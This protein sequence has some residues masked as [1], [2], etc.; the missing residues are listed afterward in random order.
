MG[1]CRKSMHASS[2][3]PNSLQDFEIYVLSRLNIPK[4]VM[5]QR[6]GYFSI[7]ESSVKEQDFFFVKNL[8]AAYF[9]AEEH[10]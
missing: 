1:Q 2:P 8:C 5:I 7:R 3:P 10:T 6:A 9:F 4:Q